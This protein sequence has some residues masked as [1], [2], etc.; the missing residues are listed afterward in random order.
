MEFKQFEII[1]TR[2]KSGVALRLPPQSKT[3]RQKTGLPP[4]RAELRRTSHEN[5]SGQG[6]NCGVAVFLKRIILSP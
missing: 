5:A 1:R 3:R 6:E 4:G 2:W